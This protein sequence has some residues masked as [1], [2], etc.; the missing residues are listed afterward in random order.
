[1][2]TAQKLYE[3]VDIGGETGT[4]NISNGQRE[5]GSGGSRCGQGSD[6]TRLWP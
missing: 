1:M 4:N 6:R 5:H 2:R 3:G